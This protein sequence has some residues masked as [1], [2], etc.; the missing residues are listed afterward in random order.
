MLWRTYFERI[1]F[2]F[3]PQV[4]QTADVVFETEIPF[5]DDHLGAFEEAAWKAM[6]EQ[7]PHWT[8]PQGGWSSVLG[9]YRY[10]P[11]QRSR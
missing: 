4:K 5:D 1:N 10:E 8:N 11:A 3:A 6:W 9:G 7:N 2:N